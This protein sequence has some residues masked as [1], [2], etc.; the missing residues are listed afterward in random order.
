MT[1]SNELTYGCKQERGYS[2]VHNKR[3]SQ[4]KRGEFKDFEKYLNGGVWS[5]N[6][7]GVGTKYKRR[8]TKIGLSL[9]SLLTS[10][11][12]GISSILRSRLQ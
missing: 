8:N 2:Q 1:Y 12:I 4:I 10:P 6:K 5:Q 9:L 11:N 3:W 7:R